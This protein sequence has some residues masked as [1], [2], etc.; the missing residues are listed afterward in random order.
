MN[1]HWGYYETDHYFKPADMLIR[2]LVECVSKNGNLILNIGPDGNGCIPEESVWILKEIGTWMKH[3]GESVIGCGG[4]PICKPEY[5][6]IT[7][8]GK[9][10][11]YHVMEGMIGGIPLIGLKKEQISRI[12]LLKTGRSL[13]VSE[14][15]ITGNYPD[16]VF[17]DLGEDPRLPDTADTVI[18]VERK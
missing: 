10:L 6:R 9:T 7:G 15:W 14:T 16:I 17:T 13:P 3:S 12:T 11:Y 5:G 8:N 2:K 18:R 1:N 4:V